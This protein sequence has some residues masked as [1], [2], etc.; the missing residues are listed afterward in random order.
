MPHLDHL[1]PAAEAIGAVNTIIVGED[2]LLTGDTTDAYGFLRDLAE[3]GVR[4]PSHALVIGSG[5]A[6]RSIVYAL[7]EAGAA[8][9]VCARDMTKARGTLRRSRSRSARGS[10]PP[11]SHAVSLRH[12]RRLP[13]GGPGSERDQ[14]GS[15]RG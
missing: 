3:H 6:A 8:V 9:M 12:R 10:G 4:I 7:A 1:T 15:A 13:G 14:P 11:R 5:G 2:G